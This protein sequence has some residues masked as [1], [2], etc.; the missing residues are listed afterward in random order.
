MSKVMIIGAGGVGG[1]LVQSAGIDTRAAARWR[2]HPRPGLA[3]RVPYGEYLDGLFA[4]AE[5]DVIP[6]PTEKHA[7]N[8]WRSLAPGGCAERWHERH[9]REHTRELRHE[10]VG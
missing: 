3:L 6:R 2:L 1:E 10:E 7:P 8:A 5:V 4:D 9:G